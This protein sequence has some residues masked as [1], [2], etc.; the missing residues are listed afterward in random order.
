MIKLNLILITMDFGL[1]NSTSKVSSKDED[2]PNYIEH[3][4]HPLK[5]R[6]DVELYTFLRSGLNIWLVHGQFNMVGGYQK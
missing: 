4:T 6:T 3:T 2:C 5:L 1:P